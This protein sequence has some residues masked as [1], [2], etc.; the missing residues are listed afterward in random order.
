MPAEL[1]TNVF[2][3]AALVAAADSGEK[4]GIDFD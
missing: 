1:L 4:F 2:W 3:G